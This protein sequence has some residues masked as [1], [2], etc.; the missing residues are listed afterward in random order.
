M[1][2]LHHPTL[3]TTFQGH[4]PPSAPYTHYRGIPYATIPHR[5][6]NPSVLTTYGSTINATTFGPRCPQ[7]PVD[8][9]YLLREPEGDIWFSTTEDEFACTNLDIAVPDLSD[10]QKDAK[11]PVF[12]WVHGGSQVV[13]YGNAGS[14]IGDVRTFVSQSVA[15]GTPVVVV[16]VQYRLGIFHVGDSETRKN[17][18]LRDLMVAL[19]WTRRYIGGFG[20]D[21][22]QI[23]LAGE[24]AGAALAHAMVVMG[25][26]VRRVALMSGSL[27]MSG[28]RPDAVGEAGVRGPV[29]E[30]LKGFGGDG[31][32]EKATVEDL[33]RAQRGAGVVSV[34]LQVEEGLKDW[35][36][37][38][39]RVEELVVGDCEYESVLWKNGVDGLSG[40]E[41]DASFTK[42]G[43]TG[44]KLKKLY[45]INKDRASSAR[46]GAL[47]LINDVLWAMPTWNL[48]NLFKQ[49]GKTAYV[50]LFD[51]ANPWQASARAHHAVD[52]LYLFEGFDISVNPAGQALA[53][54]QRRRYLEWIHGRQPWNADK[55]CVF[56]PHGRVQEIDVEEVKSR[57]RKREVGEIRKLAF[58]EVLGVLPG[59]I[60]GRISLHN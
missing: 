1:S 44:E 7:I 51:Q 58:A 47:D 9:G 2:S 8:V 24:S 17:L 57:R 27:W 30:K 23:T 33:V 11:L 43:V 40:E 48:A 21:A 37:K 35:Q 55:T 60:A 56:G 39:G 52:L 46:H 50:Y 10:T 38:T 45:H 20:G 59:L 41:I 19:E 54:E 18:G 13:S 31:D 26:E 49:Q 32:L 5:F 15:D 34:F 36:T 22:E 16:S 14:K 29:R 28:P 25:A 42:S 53:K 6:A 4:R 12:F 3:D